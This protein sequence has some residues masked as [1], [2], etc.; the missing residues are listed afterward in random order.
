[1]K[2]SAEKSKKFGKLPADTRFRE[3]AQKN[4]LKNEEKIR[5]LKEE[6]LK[7]IWG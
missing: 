1:L 7:K 5:D 3:L 4:L 2:R 6:R